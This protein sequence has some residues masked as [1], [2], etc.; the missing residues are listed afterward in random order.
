MLLIWKLGY[1]LEGNKSMRN[2]LS[3]ECLI[4][5]VLL[6]WL[7]FVKESLKASSESVQLDIYLMNGQKVALN[8]QSTDRTDDLLEVRGFVDELPHNYCILLFSTLSYFAFWNLISPAVTLVSDSISQI[9]QQV[10]IGYQLISHPS[11]QLWVI[12]PVWR[13]WNQRIVSRVYKLLSFI[14]CI[15]SA[16]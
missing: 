1:T 14:N 7:F 11:S 15:W 12:P 9:N 3:W 13:S 10:I 5:S 4:E 6:F 8:I 16:G 2:W